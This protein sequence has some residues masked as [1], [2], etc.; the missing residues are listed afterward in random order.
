MDE[1]PAKV[2]FQPCGLSVKV[3]KVSTMVEGAR[4]LGVGIE[5]LCGGRNVCG[6]CRVRIE[7]GRIR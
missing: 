4:L 6:M 2:I 3:P 1:E 5:A 7:T